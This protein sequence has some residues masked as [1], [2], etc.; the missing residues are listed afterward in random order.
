[1]LT[2]QGIDES[3]IFQ[4]LGVTDTENLSIDSLDPVELLESDDDGDMTTGGLLLL[5]AQQIFAIT[6]AVAALA[7]ESGM[8]QAPPSARPWRRSL[9]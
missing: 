7:E 6:N 3:T 1:M 8:T 2:A 9:T 5:Q 4:M